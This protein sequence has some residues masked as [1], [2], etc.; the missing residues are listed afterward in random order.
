MY[1]I[2]KT[3]HVFK[4]LRNNGAVTQL[5]K[6]E[7]TNT[8]LFNKNHKAFVY[9]IKLC[10]I[11]LLEIEYI[12]VWYYIT[13]FQCCVEQLYNLYLDYRSLNGII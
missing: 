13:R 9:L 5:F 7:S 10:T 4:L 6:N 12:F 11:I 2:N 3:S 8:Y 1:I